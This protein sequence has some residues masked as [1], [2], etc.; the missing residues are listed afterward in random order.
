MN[1]LQA[2]KNI[3][4]YFN[5]NSVKYKYL[6]EENKPIRLDALDTVYLCACVP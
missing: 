3:I 1:K 6:N 2:K 5:N 4:D